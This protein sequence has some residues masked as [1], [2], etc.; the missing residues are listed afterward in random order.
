MASAGRS[1]RATRCRPPQLTVMSAPSSRATTHGATG[2]Q[3]VNSVGTGRVVRIRPPSCTGAV[4]APGAPRLTA[5]AV[6]DTRIDLEWTRRRTITAAAP[7]PATRSR[8]RPTAA[9]WSD[10][11]ANTSQDQHVTYNH[12]GLR[13]GSRRYYRVSAI[14]SIGAG[15][16]SNVADTTT[17]DTTGP[18]VRE[19]VSP[20]AS[21]TPFASSNFNEPISTRVRTAHAACQRLHRHRRRR[22]RSRL[23]RSHSVAKFELSPWASCPARSRRVRPSR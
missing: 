23:M 3:A 10:L 6:S 21:A 14:N 19:A 22:S 18:I 13:S 9:D 1:W 5:T 16:P 2:S 15:N 17:P 12:T 4:V 7:S 11:V 20:A 8:C